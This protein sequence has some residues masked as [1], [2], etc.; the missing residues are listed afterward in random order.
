MSGEFANPAFEI[1]DRPRLPLSVV[2][3]QVMQAA[4]VEGR[5]WSAADFNLTSVDVY[6]NTDCPYMCGHCFLTT[7]EL[8]TKERMEPELVQ[9]IADWATT[10]GSRIEE[11][12]LLGGEISMH[13]QAAEI[14]KLVGETNRTNGIP[15]RP[16]IVTNGGKPFQKLL[17]DPEVVDLLRTSRVA[18]SVESWNVE[19][20]DRL[21]GRGAFRNARDTVEMLRERDIPTDI[22]C[23]IMRSTFYDGPRM[24]DLAHYWGARRI[25]FHSFSPIGR[26]SNLAEEALSPHE[27]RDF[28]EMI[29]YHKYDNAYMQSW[30]SEFEVD[31]ELG[32]DFGLPRDQVLG[33]CAISEGRN[34]QFRPP[35]AGAQEVA[36]V[37]CGLL[38][39]DPDKSAY[40][41]KDGEL[42]RR[43]GQSEWGLGR[44]ASGCCPL[45]HRQSDEAKPLCIYTRL[46][47]SRDH[48]T[49]PELL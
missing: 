3:Q 44:K 45:P 22:N 16:R 21:R 30:G 35:K 23:T 28:C 39:T 36:V 24:V 14:I 7:Q 37:A 5:P 18:V 48:V 27:W 34:L 20:N 8:T 2:G 13:P 42:Y 43:A 47:E 33:A 29:Q 12:T 41:F 19:R 46:S 10:P 31:V 17:Q 32:Y 25:N 26:G 38:M 6:T 9:E 40:V 4:E 15:L 11:L 49:P 1:G